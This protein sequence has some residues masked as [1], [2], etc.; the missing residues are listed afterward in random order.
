MSLTSTTTPPCSGLCSWAW[1]CLSPAAKAEPARAIATEARTACIFRGVLSG[2]WMGPTTGR[3]W[4]QGLGILVVQQRLGRLATE[5]PEHRRREEG[6]E[7]RRADQPGE[8]DHG[9]RVQ[10]LGA[11]LLGLEQQ[12]CQRKRSDQG[13]HQH[14][15]QALQ[16]A[17]QDHLLVEGPPLATPQV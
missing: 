6:V 15:A 4:S 10:H 14:R 13:G 1:S 8:D 5:E 7:Q 12:R 9:Q 17:T 2:W 3:T 16:R 11:G